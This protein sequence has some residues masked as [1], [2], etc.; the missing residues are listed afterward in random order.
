MSNQYVNL[1]DP[2]DDWEWRALIGRPRGAQEGDWWLFVLNG[3][4][5]DSEEQPLPLL[6]PL[7]S[8]SAYIS[9]SALLEKLFRRLTCLFPLFYRGVE[10]R[11]RERE[12]AFDL[13]MIPSFQNTDEAYRHKSGFNL[14]IQIDIAIKLD[15]YQMI[16][17]LSVPCGPTKADL[18]CALFNCN[19]VVKE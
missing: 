1:C 11:E 10:G 2:L 8:F 6:S 5:D 15:S 14:N 19:F 4:T 9:P 12:G 16:S 17:A 7:L 13:S 3:D 18:Y